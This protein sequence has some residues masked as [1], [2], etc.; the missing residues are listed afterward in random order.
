VAFCCSSYSLTY[1]YPVKCLNLD[2]A[3]EAS[4]Y[5]GLN[6]EGNWEPSLIDPHAVHGITAS[7]GSHILVGRAQSTTGYDAFAVKVS[8]SGQTIWTWRSSS[9]GK[10]AANAV[11]EIPGGLLGIVGW[12]TVGSAGK[13]SLTVL[14]LITGSERYTTT[15]FG[16]SAGSH[17]A[18]EMVSID[19]NSIVLS[20]V[21]KKPNLDEMS[22]KSYGN[23]PNGKAFVQSL[24]I[25]QLQTGVVSWTKEFSDYFTAKSVHVLPS[26]KIAA[27]LYSEEGGKQAST[28]LLNS[29]GSVQW[30]TEHSQHG[31]GTDLTVTDDGDWIVITGQGGDGFIA[32]RLTKVKV[33]DG[34]S[35]WTKDF[36]VGGNPN[37]IYQECWGVIATSDG[38]VVSC[39]AGIEGGKCSMVSGQDK[40]DCKKGLGDRRNGALLRKENNWQSFVFKTDFDGETLWQRV[41]SHKCDDCKSMNSPSFDSTKTGSSA[42]EWISKGN[43]D[44]EYLIITDEVFGVGALILTGDGSDSTPTKTP[45]STPANTPV[46]T[47]TNTPVAA[48]TPNNICK[49]STLRMIQGEKKTTVQVGWKK[50]QPL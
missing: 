45:V 7:D 2:K 26:G 21:S 47:P 1:T 37:L 41:D 44:G 33:S 17:G 39:G 15:S 48:P 8:P 42:A 13:R 29:N 24:P 4:R 27:L 46:S 12:R 50:D 31:E 20:G 5:T 35:V 22:F 36:T 43:A 28:T 10:D 11:V 32:G 19:S 49:D 16:D 3:P 6:P 9:S 34:S 25:S 14:D 23:V 30:T 38:F 40:Q 18:F